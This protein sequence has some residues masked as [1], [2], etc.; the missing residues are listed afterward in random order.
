M[1]LNYQ[2]VKQA[3][4]LLGDLLGDELN[5][6]ISAIAKNPG[7][8]N[9]FYIEIPDAQV[10]DLSV[11][12]L[13]S[14]VARTS[15]VYGRILRFSGMARA[16]RKLAEARLKRKLKV[17]MG[18]PGFSNKEAREANAYET[19]KAEVSALATIEAV[20]ELAEAL[21]IHCRVASESARKLFD[22]VKEMY[23]ASAREQAGHYQ[24]QDFGY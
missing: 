24:S 23:V 12:E 13:A 22:K 15:N 14:L 17:A 4:D 8:E 16:E 1:A 10:V 7:E 9:S 18:A 21:E 6:I 2:K 19:C 11:E 3:E 20:V 5:E